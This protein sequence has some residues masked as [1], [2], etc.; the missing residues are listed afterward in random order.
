M[1]STEI[2]KWLHEVL[3]KLPLIK[4][5][6]SFD[7]KELPKDGIY[8]F[9][10]E[11]ETWGHGGNKPRIVRIGSHKKGNFRTRIKS[12]YLFNE[13]RIDKMSLD[14]PKPA[15]GS[16]MRNHIGKALLAKRDRSY[17][18]IW[19]KS[20][21]S[22]ENRTK[23]RALRNIELEKELEIEISKIIREKFSFRFIKVPNG[24]EVMGK[25]FEGN[26]IG[27]LSHCSLC[28]KSNNWLGNNSNIDKIR[29][30]GLWLCQHLRDAPLDD[31]QKELIEK[32]VADTLD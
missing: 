10:E 25:K 21:T 29:E 1:D 31:N 28:H 20:L 12:H 3:E 15:D 2:C 9:Y 32:F 24:S 26:I 4:I 6:S 17:I 18:D 27:T 5:K 16:I 11:G 14:R 8:F 7:I 13:S 30:S 22:R 19:T 23:Y